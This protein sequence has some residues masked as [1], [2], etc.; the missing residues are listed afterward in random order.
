MQGKVAPTC[1]KDLLEQYGQSGWEW[2]RDQKKKRREDFKLLGE[3]GGQKC[4]SHLCMLIAH[5]I[6]HSQYGDVLVKCISSLKYHA[7]LLCPFNIS[8]SH[9]S[10]L[11]SKDKTPQE[12][13]WILGWPGCIINI[14]TLPKAVAVCHQCPHG[15]LLH[16]GPNLFCWE[17]GTPCWQGTQPSHT[18]HLQLWVFVGQ[19]SI[20]H[21]LKFATPVSKK[22]PVCD[23]NRLRSN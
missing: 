7:N 16:S 23:R 10:N 8:Y 9:A 11:T 6:C 2:A 18:K 1:F 22:A 14:T 13:G 15:H 3:S 5:H 19:K 21:L 17:D 12:V 4:V 20:T